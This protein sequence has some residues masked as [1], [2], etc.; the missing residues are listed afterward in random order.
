MTNRE[1][2]KNFLSL[3]YSKGKSPTRLKD[4]V[5]SRNEYIILREKPTRSILYYLSKGNSLS[6]SWDWID[7][8][9]S[10]YVYSGA[11]IL[12]EDPDTLIDNLDKFT[13]LFVKTHSNLKQKNLEEFLLNLGD[14]CDIGTTKFRDF[15][16]KDFNLN[17]EPFEFKSEKGIITI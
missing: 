2:L 10:L 5:I 15:C 4:I 16:K 8:I 1:I 9:D 17:L 6:I 12:E 7:L 11:F 13:Y 3:D 14:L